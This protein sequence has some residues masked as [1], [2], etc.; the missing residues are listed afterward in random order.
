[1][2][3]RNNE[4]GFGAAQPRVEGEVRLALVE[5]ADILIHATRPMLG[6]GAVGAE[7]IRRTQAAFLIARFGGRVVPSDGS[8][9]PLA[10]A[11]ECPLLLVR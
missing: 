4:V 7:L 3:R 5:R 2:L 8:L 9:Q 11:L 1:M 6:D 10:A